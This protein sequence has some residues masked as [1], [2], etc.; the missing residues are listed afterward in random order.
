LL[1]NS[2]VTKFLPSVHAVPCARG[3]AQR[4]NADRL[5]LAACPLSALRQHAMPS[6]RVRSLRALRQVLFSKERLKLPLHAACFRLGS[7]LHALR[8]LAPGRG[9]MDIEA[10]VAAA[11]PAGSE[12]RAVVG[13]SSDI[14]NCPPGD[15]QK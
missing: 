8:M 1:K 15:I 11:V 9:A 5:I 3:G 14:R 6:Q 12:D 4:C 13:L 2:A 7:D 10:S